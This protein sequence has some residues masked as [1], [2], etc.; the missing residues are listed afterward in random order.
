[1][2]EYI[3]YINPNLDKY[4]KDTLI[5]GFIDRHELTITSKYFLSD[6]VSDDAQG[7][8]LN[9][10]RQNSW[11]FPRSVTGV[12]VVNRDI[13]D[14]NP[15]G[16]C[17]CMDMVK[18]KSRTG[19]VLPEE[20]F[21]ELRTELEESGNGSTGWNRPIR[22]GPPA[23]VKD[24]SFLDGKSKNE[25]IEFNRLN[26][27]EVTVAIIDMGVRLSDPFLQEYIWSNP[28]TCLNEDFQSFNFFDQSADG[29]WDGYGHGTHI[30]GIIAL[31][32][33]SSNIE[34]PKYNLSQKQHLRLLSLKIT[35]GNR[36]E[37]DLFSAICAIKYA[38]LHEVDI[39]NLSWG[40]YA[41]KMDPGFAYI[42]KTVKDSGILVV[43]SA[44]NH[45]LNTDIC[46]HWPSSFSADSEF[47]NVIS[48]AALNPELDG[49]ASFSN[50]GENS[51]QIAAPGTEIVSLHPTERCIKMTGTSAAT[52][53]IA[54]HAAIL[55]LNEPDPKKRMNYSD[56]KK[57][58]LRD[59]LISIDIRG[60][61]NP[62]GK[63]PNNKAPF[64]N[65]LDCN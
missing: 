16:T 61:S 34:I 48:V 62:S 18:Y 35:S 43:T 28:E 65:T 57:E 1:M 15:Q 4:S 50:Y 47:D 23:N 64:T 63:T 38:V 14:S 25:P 3:L 2:D 49:I 39:I 26:G 31:D 53:F 55:L 9:K 32:D 45:D 58:I 60:S 6:P 51:V 20:T 52:P 37:S 27:Q 8:N 24:L 5:Q 13:P 44:G 21:D 56:L 42:M 29:T 46:P 36:I 19:E 33:T 30:A 59:S 12:P 10:L 11:E 7:M 17:N 41:P 40:Y 22:L 54:R